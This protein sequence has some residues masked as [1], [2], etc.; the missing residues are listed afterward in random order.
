MPV[1]LLFCFTSCIALSQL[2]LSPL[3]FCVDV[4]SASPEEKKKIPMTLKPAV[5]PVEPEEDVQI[6]PNVRRCIL[7]RG[8]TG[9][10]FHL[11]C[12]QQKPGTF[13]SQ[14]Q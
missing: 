2:D 7:Q 4:T 13:I 11:G 3:L 1:C 6:D 10:G 9:F 5:P 14:V 8:S 12:V